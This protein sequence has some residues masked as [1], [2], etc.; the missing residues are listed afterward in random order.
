[1]DE[2]RRGCS[3]GLGFELPEAEPSEV[4]ETPR[5]GCPAVLLCVYEERTEARQPPWLQEPVGRGDSCD[6]AALGSGLAAAR[7]PRPSQR[8]ASVS[9]GDSGGP[10]VCEEPSGRFFLAGIVSWGIGCAEARRPGVYA[11]VTRLRDWILEAI[12]TAGRPLAPTAAP[13]STTASTARPT[14]PESPTRPTLGLSA[15]PPDSVTASKPQ[16]TF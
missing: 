1:M 4:L 8:R 13:A 14:S 5:P 15:A 12:T 7:A 6:S 9:Q 11:R 2:E 3:F 10:L 16:G